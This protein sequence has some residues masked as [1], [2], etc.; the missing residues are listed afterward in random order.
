MLKKFLLI[1]LMCIAVMAIVVPQVDAGCCCSP[2]WCC[3]CLPGSAVEY[4]KATGLGNV[5]NLCSEDGDYSDCPAGAL[6]MIGVDRQKGKK[7]VLD[8]DGC[9]AGLDPTDPGSWD[10]DCAIVAITKCQNPA[11]PHDLFFN[12]GTAFRVPSFTSG[13]QT[14]ECD[15]NGNCPFSISVGDEE[16]K[17][18][19]KWTP[20]GTTVPNV[21]IS[22]DFCPEGYEADG[23]CCAERNF[24][25]SGSPCIGPNYGLI[26]GV[27]YY[28]GEGTAYGWGEGEADR[29]FEICEYVPP[30]IDETQDPPVLL[31]EERFNCRACTPEFEN[32][33][34]VGWDCPS[35]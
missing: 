12:E 13:F 28:D 14:F 23:T 15:G 7:S 17:C 2:R 35:T 27:N 4:C 6:S 19:K 9:L 29:I 3:G 10:P 33:D 8:P 25:A 20:Q 32:S 1:S 16:G 11:D 24:D 26:N 21:V 30:V 22:G 18:K 34:I 31:E 5:W